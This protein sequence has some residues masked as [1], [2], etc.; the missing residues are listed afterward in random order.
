[1]QKTRHGFQAAFILAAAL[2]TIRNLFGFTKATIES[3]CPGGGIESLAFYLKNNAFLC[4]VSGI[5]LLLFI[6]I[7]IGTLIAGRAFCSWVCPIGTVH[8]CISWAGKTAGLRNDS[9]WRGFGR[10]AGLVKYPVLLLVL[11]ATMTYADLILRPFCPYYVGMSGQEHEVGWWSKWLMLAL[12]WAGLVLP[13][14]WC[15]L[16]CP[17]GTTLG[18]IRVVSPAVPTINPDRCTNC[19]TCGSNCPQQIQVHEVRRVW[20]SECTSCL[21][22]VD[23]CPH[24]A[25]AMKAGYFVPVPTT[26]VAVTGER[27]RFGLSRKFVPAI[28]VLMMLAGIM[29]AWNIPMPTFSKA[30]LNFGKTAKTASIEMIVTGLRCRGTASTLSWIIEQDDGILSFDAYVAEHRAQ[31]LYDPARLNPAGIKALIEDGR[32][33]T[34]KKTGTGKLLRPFKVETILP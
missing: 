6:A 21:V 1:M 33:Q 31:I 12:A 5:N 20:S 9:A 11:Y 30:Y 17:L 25:I 19:G 28:V 13:F 2:L 10:Y 16:L 34:D 18:I 8:E 22:C 24:R 7:A 4:A 26:P 14:F 29:A 32:V 15:R 27:K 3:W 23:T